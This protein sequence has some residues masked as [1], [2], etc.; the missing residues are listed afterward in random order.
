MRLRNNTALRPT[1]IKKETV[2]T[3]AARMGWVYKRGNVVTGWKRRFFILSGMG[4][5]YYANDLEKKCKGCIRL[6]GFTV[7]KVDDEKHPHCFVLNPPN[8]EKQRVWFLSTETAEELKGWMDA[9]KRAQK[10]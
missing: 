10:H 9:I 8:P 7:E 5:Y 3:C 2:V 4:L 1:N 6:G